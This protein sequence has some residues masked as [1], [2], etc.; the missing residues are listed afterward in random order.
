MLEALQG[1]DV[2]DTANITVRTAGVFAPSYQWD[3]KDQG[4]ETA[5]L[6]VSLMMDGDVGAIDEYRIYRCVNGADWVQV[7]TTEA[8]TFIDL[9]Q[10]EERTKYGYRINA[11]VSGEETFLQEL[12]VNAGPDEPSGCWDP[13]HVPF[14][15][16]LIPIVGV[17]LFYIWMK[18]KKK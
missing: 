16:L 8:P 9:V 6:T 10:T 4:N 3:L 7:Q 12:E 11:T 2:I 1:D 5:L 18:R 14:L 17:G 13:D 15:L